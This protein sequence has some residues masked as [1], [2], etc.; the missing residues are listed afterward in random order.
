MM[1]CAVMLH[2]THLEHLGISMSIGLS[3][4]CPA[5]RAGFICSTAVIDSVRSAM[6]LGDLGLGGD[7]SMWFGG[8]PP[9][10]SSHSRFAVGR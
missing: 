1:S 7:T 5:G 6:Y 2:L 9:L 8:C 10:S 4:V 3:S